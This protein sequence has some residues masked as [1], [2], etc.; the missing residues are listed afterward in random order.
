[1]SLARSTASAALA[2][3][4][5]G[6][7]AGPLP[8]F[9]IRMADETIARLHS[10]APVK[11]HATA[12]ELFG[13]EFLEGFQQPGTLCPGCSGVGY[14]GMLAGQRFRRE[15]PD[16]RDDVMRGYGYTL[17]TVDGT[18]TVG[19]EAS[20][21]TPKHDRKPTPED[22]FEWNWWVTGW[23]ADFVG[24]PA[25]RLPGHSKPL[26]WACRMTGWLSP[27]GSYGHMNGYGHRFQVVRSEF[28]PAPDSAP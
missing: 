28:I 23:S 16:R 7:S 13:W 4:A 11:D 19:F 18:C 17:T 24:P 22:T 26:Q 3:V 14:E 2:L 6:A 1:M 10:L 15:H 21:F 9:V 12:V 27:R 8:D 25:P 20:R 5:T